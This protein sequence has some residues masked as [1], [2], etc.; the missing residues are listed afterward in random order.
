MSV[1]MLNI[2][3]QMQCNFDAVQLII[4]INIKKYVILNMNVWTW[5][6]PACRVF[7]VKS[8]PPK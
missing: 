4:K 8:P 3:I 1:C 2:E 6:K 5:I 7:G